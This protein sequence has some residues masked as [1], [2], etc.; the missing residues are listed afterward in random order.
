[1]FPPLSPSSTMCLK[2]CVF[3]LTAMSDTTAL[4]VSGDSSTVPGIRT[5]SGFPGS[6]VTI[7]AISALPSARA[8]GSPIAV[9]SASRQVGTVLFNPAREDQRRRLACLDEIADFQHRQV[10][11][12]ERVAHL[13]RTRHVRDVDAGLRVDGR[14]RTRR[15][16]GCG[17]LSECGWRVRKRDEK[18]S[19]QIS[20]HGSS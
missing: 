20:A 13:D 9:W 1:M 4:K 5:R 17:R 19:R 11:N 7:G 6:R 15:L 16:G 12:P 18:K 14:D 10:L 8:I 2:P 3:R